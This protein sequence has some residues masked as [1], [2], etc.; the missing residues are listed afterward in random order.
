MC[1]NYS[2]THYVEEFL[3]HMQLDFP[4]FCFL[5]ALPWICHFASV[6]G[7]FVRSAMAWAGPK[8]YCGAI[9]K[10]IGFLLKQFYAYAIEPVRG[11]KVRAILG[12]I[13]MRTGE[14]TLRQM[15]KPISSFSL[16]GGNVCVWLR[17]LC[18]LLR[19]FVF[20]L[21]GTIEKASGVLSTDTDKQLQCT[22]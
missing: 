13:Q 5:Y 19:E 21:G 2:H 9:E 6:V 8:Q 1:S 18:T 22:L 7:C 3:L 20:L 16:T 15:P 14:Y 12:P 17:G 4:P 10:I 11:V